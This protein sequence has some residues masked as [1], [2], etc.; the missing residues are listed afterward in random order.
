MTF[1]IPRLFADK[2]G[3]IPLSELDENFAAIAEAINI[4]QLGDWTI[5][6]VEGTI[7]FSIDGAKKMKL[8]TSGNITVVGNV[9]AFGEV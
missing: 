9:T 3:Q 1:F 2:T 5:T 6:E 4:V 7:F 8:D